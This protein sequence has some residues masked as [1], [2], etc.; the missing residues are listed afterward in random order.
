MFDVHTMSSEFIKIQLLCRGSKCADN[1][2][3]DMKT[4][5]YLDF[6]ILTNRSRD[7]GL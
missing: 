5:D 3:E 2:T 4:C 1:E 6:R 7:R